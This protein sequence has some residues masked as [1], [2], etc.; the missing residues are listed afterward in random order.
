MGIPNPTNKLSAWIP[1]HK[2]ECLA[3]VSKPIKKSLC[4]IKKSTKAHSY[5]QH[6]LPEP[7]AEYV[8]SNFSTAI[9]QHREKTP[10]Q[11]A[12]ALWI[13][14]SHIRGKHDTCPV[15][16][17]CRWRITTSTAHPIPATT[18]NFSTPEVTKVREVFNIFATEEFCRHLTLGM[19][20]NENE[21]IHN[22]IW[23]FC[24]KAKYISPQ[25]I[26]IGTG[27]AVTFF[28]DGKLSL[29]GLL[30]DLKHNPSYTCFST[31]CR[32]EHTRKQNLNPPSK[33][34]S[35][36]GLGGKEQ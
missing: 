6:K 7:K 27:I 34:T 32:R 21:S 3:H 25:S 16:S 29:Y 35:I 18:T 17:W 22:T 1:I 23:N 20:Q 33:R 2:E 19:T 26:G 31:L 24:P 9:L 13:L 28:N 30:S 8:S 12:G 4:R 36:A 5:I 11:M 15:D 14:F 10:T